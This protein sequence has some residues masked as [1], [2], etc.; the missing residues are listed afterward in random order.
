MNVSHVGVNFGVLLFLGL[1]LVLVLLAVLPGRGR[2]LRIGIAIGLFMLVGL[3]ALV[4]G[5]AEVRR[6]VSPV[7]P[8]A[9]VRHVQAVAQATPR[10]APAL[11]VPPTTQPGP[12]VP[13]PPLPPMLD[14]DGQIVIEGLTIPPS[15]AEEMPSN[16]KEEAQAAAEETLAA[17]PEEFADLLVRYFDRL[18]SGPAPAQ[19]ELGQLRET[20]RGISRTQRRQLAER[21]AAQATEVRESIVESVRVATSQAVSAAQTGRTFNVSIDPD[22]IRELARSLRTNAPSSVPHLATWQKI[23]GTILVVIIAALIL[24]AATRRHSGVRYL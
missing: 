7:P 15:V 2:G 22:R 17:K 5:R 6:S 12:R 4:V 23:A 18:I 1:A 9:A 11:L 24:K 16:D 20:L 21:A 19:E 3:A 13:A 8:V 10:P 14:D